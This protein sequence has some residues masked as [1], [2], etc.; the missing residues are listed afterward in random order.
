VP[1]LFMALFLL[2]TPVK[3]LVFVETPE[4]Q[5]ATVKARTPVVLIA[6]DEFDTSSLMNRRQA[7]DAGR[8]PNLARFGREST[9][10][11]RATTMSWLSED[12][13][14]SI[15]TGTFPAPSKLPVLAEYPQNLFT[16]LGGSYRVRAI[17]TLTHL[18]PA[19]VCGDTHPAQRQT[20]AVAA[21]FGSLASDVGIVY[22]HLLLPEPYVNRVPSIDDSWGDFG[23][24]EEG[25]EQVER[26]TTGEIKPCGRNV[27]AFADM[28]AADRR[29][30]LYFLDTLL[31][32][33]PYVYLPSARRYAVD[34][35]VL[36][37]FN[38]GN[39]GPDP[40]PVL[41]SEQRYL[42]Q[43]GYTDRALGVILD[44]LRATGVY[45]RALV[46]VTADHGVSFHANGRR[47]L[48]TSSNLEDIAFVPLFVKLPRQRKG[49]V[50]DSLAR[51]IDVL[52]TIARVLGISV[53][54]RMDGRPLVGGRVPRNGLVSV[55]TSAGPVQMPLSA[56]SQRLARALERRTA[57]FGTGS[58][59]P[60]YRFGPHRDLHG[61]RTSTLTVRPSASTRVRLDGAS[62]LEA[63]DPTSGFLPSFVEGRLTGR[64]AAGQ[65]LAIGVNGVIAAT[66]QT[67]SQYG[68]TRFSA[69]VP[70]EAL[71]AGRNAVAV[72]AI[73]G[74]GGSLVLEELRSSDLSL[75]LV[76]ENGRPAIKTSA[77]RTIRITPRALPGTVRVSASN[78]GY[79]FRGSAS[80]RQ[81]SS[82][83]DA[84]VVFADERAVY[85]GR[86]SDLRPQAI[87]GQAELGKF[88]YVFEL[89]RALLPQPGSGQRVRVFAVRGLVASELAH[90]GAWPWR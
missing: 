76:E 89:P 63:V 85:R 70:E 34:A 87:L 22:L 10:F 80:H 43:V 83:P 54:W 50:D 16:L 31:P 52:P 17:E 33:T 74:T 51:T 61:R 49:R 5:A 2:N 23:Q 66:T 35:R 9:W 13:V 75:R 79:R 46:I 40:W 72:Y 26:G 69:L 41:Q 42:L 48:P 29:P 39:W 32:H 67:F 81:T 7:I 6:F 20:E 65:K 90:V 62:L 3:R 14:P 88:G 38:R 30:T 12:S 58:F 60:L 24:S 45:D 47:R 21:E 56:L 44:K 73:R 27:C 64:A 1:L 68:E 55:R 86:A 82:R 37:G 84:L 28:I 8:Y 4:V 77:G 71:R 11:R 59:A 19:K 18:C 53:P 25:A 78:A 36:R 15:L 57:R